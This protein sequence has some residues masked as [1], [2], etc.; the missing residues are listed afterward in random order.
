[1]EEAFA[2]NESV[3]RERNTPCRKHEP[4][5]ADEDGIAT[6]IGL[7]AAIAARGDALM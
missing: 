5:A 2:Q 1:M 4:W 7:D 3:G 6:R